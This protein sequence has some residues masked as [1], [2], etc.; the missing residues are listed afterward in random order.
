MNCMDF[1]RITLAGYEQREGGYRQHKSDCK[2]C[3]QFYDE[4]KRF[5]GR[6]EK[7]T[8]VRT[9]DDLK[10]RIL[11]HQ[12]MR[13]ERSYR[14]MRNLQYALVASMLLAVGLVIGLLHDDNRMNLREAVIHYVATGDTLDSI[15]PDTDAGEIQSLLSEFGMTVNNELS[16]VLHAERCR[17]RKKESLLVQVQGSHGPVMLLFMPADPVTEPIAIEASYFSGLITPCPKGSV[18]I[19]GRKGEDIKALQ[20]TVAESVQWF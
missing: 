2:A 3:A 19:I 5:N 14:R 17:I 20:K 7:S 10:S 8:R 11:L 13:L 6:L 16:P 15:G 12:S 1:R 9:P 18:A 4:A